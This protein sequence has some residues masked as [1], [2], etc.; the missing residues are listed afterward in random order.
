MLTL[1]IIN[2]V[3]LISTLVV[4]ICYA[5][6]T[7]RIAN[8]TVENSIRPV[9]LRG[10]HI[11]SWKNIKL[12]K[13]EDIHAIVEKPITFRVLKNI[14]KDIEGEIIIEKKKYK[15]LFGNDVTK[16]EIVEDNKMKVWFLPKWGWMDVN[17]SIFAVPDP[18]SAK[19]T[20]RNNGIMLIYRDIQNNA[21]YT[22][23]NEN[24]IQSS[25]KYSTAT[26]KYIK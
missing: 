14:A 13:M 11:E 24:F 23:E 12:L 19:D 9:I 22:R 16:I 21:Y 6:D 20:E 8:Q 5:I 26:Q 10:G 3:V 18:R 1:E 7:H 25:G 2:L 4:L 17:S 15:L